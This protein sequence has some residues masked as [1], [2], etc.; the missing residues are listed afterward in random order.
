MYAAVAVARPFPEPLTYAVPAILVGELRVGHVVLVPLGNVAETGYVVELLDTTDVP[1]DKVKSLTRLVDPVVAFD[2][3]QLGFFRWVADYYL[4]PLGMVIHTALPS[5]MRARVVKAAEATQDGIQALTRRSVEGVQA[6]LLREIISRPG[7]TRRGLVRRLDGEVD[8][9]DVERTVDGL[10]RA[11][12]VEWVDREVGETRAQ[13]RT[14][15]LVQPLE[16]V[17]AA[18]PRA[19]STQRAVLGA[20]SEAGGPIDQADVTKRFGSHATKVIHQLA[21]QGFVDVGERE[22]RDPLTDAV[23]LGPAV[24]PALNAHQ[25][26]ALAA[27]TSAESGAFLLFGV[28]GAG[29][30]EVFLGAAK[31]ALEKGRQVLVLVPEIGLTPQLVG[32]FRARFGE[33]V[34]VLHSGLTSAQRLA[35]WRRIRAREAP[36]AVGA[37][38]A[39]FAPFTELGLIVVDE[40]HDDSY[41][42]DEGVPYSARDLAVVLGARVGC[43]VV[44]ATATP[45]LE[46]WNNCEAGRYTRVELPERATPRPVP[47]VELV[48]MTELTWP[49]GE[50]RPLFAPQVVTALRQTFDNGG[51]AIVLYNRRGYATMVQCTSCGGTW[52]CPN[53]GISMTLHKTIARMSCHY[54]GL[55]LRYDRTCPVCHAGAEHQEELGKGTEQV[56]E[57]L[58]SLFPDIPLARMDADTTS[59]R[60]AHHRILEGFRTGKTRMLVGTQI[61]AKGHDFPDVHTAVVVSADRGFRIPDFRSAERTYALLVQVAGR[62]GRGDVPGRVLVQTWKPD[63]YVLQCLDDVR[64]F[65]R[66]EVRLRQTL[67]YPP[68]SRLCLL[69][70]DGV[71]RKR[72][73]AAAHALAK[74]LRASGQRFPKTAVLGPAAAALPRLVGRWRFQIV[75]RG[76]HTAAFRAWLKESLPTIRAA[77]TKGIRVSW[78][79]DPRH[80]M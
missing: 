31:A 23:A 66:T 73:D 79:V 34:A 61:V 17:L 40:E 25:T 43:P 47:T 20:L 14:V 16:D 35:E 52:E 51:K 26:A 37:R 49:E 59:G 8:R 4:V 62:A 15:A 63:H 6:Q 50:E 56:E 24:A 53:C 11:G 48:D 30:T 46:T 78:D 67:R 10:V 22:R 42:Q 32:R 45:S 80:L 76:E 44:L 77:A 58:R 9:P 19:G 55:S 18:L 74:A 39:L 64:G 54:C 2:D 13:V 28:T 71:D 21:E 5:T 1:P 60:G 57:V 38:S 72:T 33:A 27:I 7:L 3:T 29:K 12:L 36:V 41:K 65:L 70:I 68:Y 69:R 75:L